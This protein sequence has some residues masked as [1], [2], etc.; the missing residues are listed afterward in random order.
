ME[1]SSRTH[2]DIRMR[3]PLL[4]DFTPAA[5]NAGSRSTGVDNE[6]TIKRHGCGSFAGG[7]YQQ[8]EPA[9][10]AEDHGS[11]SAGLDDDGGLSE[12]QSASLR[13]K[14]SGRLGKDALSWRHPRST[15]R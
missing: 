12:R 13:L 6:N 3:F 7:L 14:L 10:P 11:R 8:L 5:Q 2:A 1:I 15:E 4:P 9:S